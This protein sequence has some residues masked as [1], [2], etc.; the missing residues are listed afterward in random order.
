MPLLDE[1]TLGTD[2]RPGAQWAWLAVAAAVLLIWIVLA[3]GVSFI[4]RP[5]PAP[6][7]AGP[8]PVGIPPTNPALGQANVEY[9]AGNHQAALQS[10]TLAGKP[11]S[12]SGQ[13]RHLYYRIGAESHAALGQHAQSADLYEAYLSMGP[14]IYANGCRSCHGPLFPTS[15]AAMRN[16]PLGAQ[17][18]RELL[19]SGRLT[20]RLTTLRAQLAKAP[21]DP[22]LNLLLYHL[23]T[24]SGRTAAATRHGSRLLQYDQKVGRLWTA[25]PRRRTSTPVPPR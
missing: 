4:T 22:R 15:L 11:A 17:Y 5:T 2:R 8:A 13:D 24:A 1:D 10:L 21:N 6:P 7:P 9:A 20:Q 23:E 3:F 12:L 16:S 25:A 18:T 19:A 14:Q